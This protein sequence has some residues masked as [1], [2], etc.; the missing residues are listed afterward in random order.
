[1]IA[2]HT[3]T[4]DEAEAHHHHARQVEEEAASN[5][6][7][8]HDVPEERKGQAGHQEAVAF[9]G[10]GNQSI[11]HS[12]TYGTTTTSVEIDRSKN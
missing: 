11:D 5:R 3:R 6:A 1:M 7:R 2:P 8:P 10:G 12:S 9:C 4:L